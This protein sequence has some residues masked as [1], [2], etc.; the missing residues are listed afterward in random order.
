LTSSTSA[1]VSG[2]PRDELSLTPLPR[3]W[4]GDVREITAALAT[5]A[6]D[7]LSSAEAHRRF[8]RLGANELRE[9]PT[10][11]RW[12]L[13]GRQTA[14]TMTGVLAVAAI[15]TL[16]IGD[17]EDTAVITAVV[18][19]NAVIGLV[20]EERA[21]QAV[22]ALKRL[23]AGST[24]VV[25]DGSARPVPVSDVVIGDL[26]L[27]SSGDRV[28]ADLRLVEAQNL[29][30]DESAL[31]G[32]AEPAAKTARRL[33]DRKTLLV[34]SQQ[35]MAFDSTVVTFGRGRGVV[36]ATGMGTEVGQIAALLQAHNPGMTPLQR[37]LGVLGRRL[38]AAAMVVCVGVFVAGLAIG[39]PAD[40]MFLRAV[41]LA[42]AAIPEGLPAVVTVA[43]ALGARRMAAR[44]AL[45][46]RLPAVETLGSVSVICTDKTGTLTQNRMTVERVWTPLGS[47]EVSGVGYE[48]AGTI[49]TPAG[50]PAHDPFLHRLAAVAAACNDAVLHAPGESGEWSCTGDPTEGALLAFAA[51]LGV[52]QSDLAASFPRHA[53]IAFDA[54][55]R[56]MTTLHRT[57]TGVWV[58]VKGAL[59]ALGPLLRPPDRDR[60]DHAGHVADQLAAAGYRVLAFAERRRTGPSPE[61]VDGAEHDLELVGLVGI[62]DPPR[63]EANA[64]VAACRAAGITPVM[65]TGDHPGT[66]RAISRRVGLLDDRE[67]LTGEALDRLS[68]AE[69]NDRVPRVG[70]YARTSPAQKLRIVE[71]WKARGAVVAMTGD[72][73][74]DAP[75]L[76]RADIGIAMGLTGT[77]V[78]KEAAD[79]V[80]ADDRFATI[81]DAVSEGRRIYDNIRRFIRYMLATN[82]GELWAMFLAPMLGLPFPLLP[83]QILWI[84]LVTDGP[85][86]IALGLEPVE[87]DA[88]QRPPR[89]L[90][91][92]ILAGGLWQQAVWVGLL[93]AAVIIVL[94]ATARAV[95]WP[96]QTMVFATLSFLSLGAAIAVRSERQSV[97]RLGLRSNPWMVGALILSGGAQLGAIY[98]P[99][100]RGVFHADPLTPVQL[101]VSLLAATAVLVAVE[102]EKLIRHRIAHRASVANAGSPLGARR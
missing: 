15:V 66:A 56:R 89:P 37:R 67:V 26:V 5:D 51:K 98:L 16:V 25:R 12:H 38:A 28:P 7:G 21:Q 41:S 60:L 9:A 94:Q 100:L 102:A 96:W 46:R 69:L 99:G 22:A 14:N 34:A 29:R 71:A 23:A 64:S 92:S 80:L 33:P 55:R 75:A 45:V 85:P 73:V 18:V 61:P 62:A 3:P 83:A 30:V 59:A 52:E 93:M 76:R 6:N 84:N 91:E 10:P 35:N 57:P 87:P 88:M 27:L 54:G 1:S 40:T 74:N 95:G 90:D 53:E 48:P 2:G 11:S 97:R 13:I 70:I 32:E 82:S 50:D 63:P 72:G 58:A 86:A 78:S 68:D 20:Q 8:E 44:R 24:V 36:V 43:L 42:V 31:T 79:L 4:A 65:I 49:S 77:D 81:L 47:Y 17:P 101:A 19:L 39:E